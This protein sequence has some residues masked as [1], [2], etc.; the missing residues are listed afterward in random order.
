MSTPQALLA[1]LKL[2]ARDAYDLPALAVPIHRIS[3]G[4]GIMLQTD[5][6]INRRVALGRGRGAD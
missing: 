1:E 5:E 6:E 3:Q 2:P 4:S